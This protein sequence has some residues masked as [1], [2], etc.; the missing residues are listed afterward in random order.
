MNTLVNGK[1]SKYVTVYPY[2]SAID[3]SA[4]DFDKGCKANYLKNISIYGDAIRV[5]STVTGRDVC[6]SWYN[7]YSVYQVLWE[8][9]SLKG[10]C[11]WNIPGSGLFAFAS[12]GGWYQ[13][14]VGFR[15]VLVT[16]E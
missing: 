15:S 14:E 6:T 3:N 9:F 7:N 10:G 5:I 1:S 12:N 13:G 16:K 8:C 2:D 4:N 11:L